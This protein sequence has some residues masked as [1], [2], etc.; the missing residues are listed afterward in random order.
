MTDRLFSLTT[1]SSA[2]TVVAGLGVNFDAIAQMA[3]LP[4]GVLGDP[5]SLVTARQF[6]ELMSLGRSLFNNDPAFSLNVADLARL[7]MVDVIGPLFATTATLRSYLEEARRFMPIITPCVDID[8]EEDGDEVRL[9]CSIPPDQGIDERFYHAEVTFAVGHKMAHSVFKQH[10]IAPLRVE[11]QHDGSAWLSEYHR[12]FSAQT[13]VLF[14]QPRNVMVLRREWLDIA[15]PGH[16]PSVHAHMETLALARLAALPKVESYSARVLRFLEQE[17]GG[18]VL[19]LGD[20]ATHLGVTTRTLQ[21]RLVDERTTFQVLRDGVRFRQACTMLS[22]ADCDIATI[23]ATLGF[24][25]PATFQ[26]AFRSWSGMS[27]GEYRRRH[28]PGT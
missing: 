3:G 10:D 5:K 27:P 8:I 11:M 22:R 15:N 12:H 13:E 14:R 18:R 2:I 20:V 16:S 24:S 25:E 7:E 4:H 1:Y 23:A 19:D 21:R 9:V 6:H 28:T 17:N 26:R